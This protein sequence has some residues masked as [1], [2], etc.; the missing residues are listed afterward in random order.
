MKHYNSFLVGVLF[1]FVLSACGSGGD[2]SAGAGSG[3]N[4]DTGGVSQSPIVSLSGA[5]TYSQM[6]DQILPKYFNTTTIDRLK[7]YDADFLSYPETTALLMSDGSRPFG[8]ETVGEKD[9]WTNY[10]A[11]GQG[12]ANTWP[13]QSNAEIT[14]TGTASPRVMDYSAIDST[15]GLVGEGEAKLYWGIKNVNVAQSPHVPIVIII[16]QI[17]RNNGTPLYRAISIFEGVL[18]MPITPAVGT[19]IGAAKGIRAQY[20]LFAVEAFNGGSTGQLISYRACLFHV[21]FVSAGYQPSGNW[22]V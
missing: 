13:D 1:S 5:V 22:C 14:F 3:N 18:L 7:Q 4:G 11:P 9:S 16:E 6:V 19:S 20:T 17:V 10:V 2:D 15:N 8:I 21:G 12:Y